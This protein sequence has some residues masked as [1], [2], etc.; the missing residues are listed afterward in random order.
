MQSFDLKSLKSAGA[1]LAP[2]LALAT[3]VAPAPVPADHAARQLVVPNITVP[4]DGDH[5]AEHEKHQ[6]V[7]PDITVPPTP[8]SAENAKRQLV[9][10]GITV[11]IPAIDVVGVERF[12]DNLQQSLF[13]TIPTNTTGASGQVAINNATFALGDLNVPK[14][15]GLL[16]NARLEAVNSEVREG[17]VE[18]VQ[19]TATITIPVVVQNHPE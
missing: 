4:I 19:I 13:E 12:A 8:V 18:V 10:P 3:I 6:L 16:R 14:N 1:A 2:L 17:K 15:S 11:P 9:V 5:A 7:V